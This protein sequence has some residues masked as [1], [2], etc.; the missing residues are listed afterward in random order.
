MGYKGGV[1]VETG[2]PDQG[3]IEVLRL[4]GLKKVHQR[5]VKF[6]KNL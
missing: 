2:W 6:L 5:I 1:V 4:E 3:P